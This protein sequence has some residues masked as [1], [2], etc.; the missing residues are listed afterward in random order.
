MRH[1]HER[2]SDKQSRNK[3]SGSGESGP[4]LDP[5]WLG[6]FMIA[7]TQVGYVKDLLPDGGGIPDYPRSRFS[8]HHVD[9]DIQKRF[10][11]LFGGDAD[12]NRTKFNDVADLFSKLDAYHPPACPNSETL[13]AVVDLL[14][15]LQDEIKDT[16]SRYG[17]ESK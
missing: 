10:F 17:L 4:N 11:E 3:K 5:R 1:L 6:L 15:S 9:P 16:L 8:A 13:Q 7:A 14:N 12:K 2:N